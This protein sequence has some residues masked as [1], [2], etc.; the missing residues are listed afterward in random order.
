MPPLL[1]T[2]AA[3]WR[4]VTWPEFYGTGIVPIALLA[5]DIDMDW[6]TLHWHDWL[7][8]FIGFIG[9]VIILW[10]VLQGVIEFLRAQVVSFRQK[11]PVSL[12]AIRY[13][14][15]RYILLGLEFFIAADIVHTI[16]QPTLEEV[17]VLAAIVIVRT[18]ISFFLNREMEQFGHLPKK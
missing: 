13:D 12:E 3:G 4:Y 18:I 10:G 5:Y 1:P 2:P 7:S 11:K 9:L 15:G 14:L 17:A 8:F 16:V 6:Q